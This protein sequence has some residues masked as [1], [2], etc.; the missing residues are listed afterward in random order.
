[1]LPVVW[2]HD[3]GTMTAG[4]FR[5]DFALAAEGGTHTRNRRAIAPCSQPAIASTV[6]GSPAQRPQ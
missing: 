6:A 3:P 1:M 4:C 5:A 2:S